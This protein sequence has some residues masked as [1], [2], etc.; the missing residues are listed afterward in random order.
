MLVVGIVTLLA[1]VMALN[2]SGILRD[3]SRLD[4]L[5]RQNAKP[6]EPKKEESSISSEDQLAQNI[7]A[8]EAALKVSGKAA[9]EQAPA[10]MT[11]AEFATPEEPTILIPRLDRVKPSDTNNDT[12]SQWYRD[13]AKLQADAE[14]KEELYGKSSD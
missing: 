6:P 10:Q 1:I 13:Q 7:A 12:S 4:A 11:Q 9:G 3:P 14:A 5:A 2:M 8:R